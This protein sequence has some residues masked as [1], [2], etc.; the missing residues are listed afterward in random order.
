MQT[1]QKFKEVEVRL[2]KTKWQCHFTIVPH[3]PSGQLDRGLA[4]TGKKNSIWYHRMTSLRSHCAVE[5]LPSQWA[6]SPCSWRTRCSS[7]TGPASSGWT[8]PGWS[9]SRTYG[10]RCRLLEKNKIKNWFLPLCWRCSPAF[11]H[12]SLNSGLRSLFLVA[13]LLFVVAFLSGSSTKDT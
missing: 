6:P 10:G 12:L 3:R 7:P 9:Q 13:V 2:I 4:A 5:G 1:T 11:A 8:P